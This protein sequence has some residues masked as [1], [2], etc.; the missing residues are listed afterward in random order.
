MDMVPAVFGLPVFIILL[1]LLGL[2][3]AL[4][5]RKSSSLRRPLA[6]GC[7]ATGSTPRANPGKQPANAGENAL[8]QTCFRGLSHVL[9][10]ENDKA[11]AEFVKIASVDTTT[12]EIY[13]TLGQL[14]RISGEFERALRVHRDILLR[15]NLPDSVRRQTF[16]EIGLDYKKAGLLERASKAFEEILEREP[17]NNRARYELA[18]I[19][20]SLREWEKARELYRSFPDH[21]E[22][23]NVIAHLSTEVAK[24]QAAS[25]DRKNALKN[26][27][28]ALNEDEGC[29]DAWLH[30]GDCLLAEG[31]QEAA[32]EAWERA[33]TLAPEHIGLVIR[34][35]R[36]LPG[37][38]GKELENEFFSRHLE[39]YGRIEKF[40]RA[41]SAHLIEREELEEA[42]RQLSRLM[43]SSN[44][45]GEVFALVRTLLEKISRKYGEECRLYRELVRNFF[46]TQMRF[47]KPYQ[48]RQCG[49]QLDLMVWRCPRCNRWD[50]VT[51][52]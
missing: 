47:E 17:G 32:I 40:Q 28:Q 6:G 8:L 33:F 27:R 22:R 46:S 31:R 30:Y 45:D 1:L 9:A 42:A 13:L 35:L 51:V 19:Y 2:V 5:L 41:Y 3:V 43:K 23:L 44:G 10:N 18:E 24:L 15:P 50:T 49:Y 11:V 52:K 26:F 25:G 21:R 7:P 48:C 20:I 29:I 4:L 14:F 37:E 39:S 36:Q 34:R 16:F 38:N 12:A